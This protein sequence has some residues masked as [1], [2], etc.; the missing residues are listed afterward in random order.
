MSRYASVSLNGT[1]DRERWIACS[2]CD[3]QT[4]HK[5]LVSANTYR[6]FGPNLEYWYQYEIVQCQ[7]CWTIS[8]LKNWQSSDDIYLDDDGKPKLNGHEELY[9]GRVAGRHKLRNSQYLPSQIF[10]IYNETHSA[11]CNKL[12][13]LAGVGIRALIEVV[14]KN[15]SAKGS[16]LEKKI[17][18]LVTIGVL[19]TDGASILHSLRIMGNQAAH[20]VK[21]HS[22]TDLN[23][24]FDVVEHLLEGVYLLPQK[25]KKLPKRIQNP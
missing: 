13:V 20:E 25:A 22:E 8:F 6:D 18:N 19:T 3:S 16:D 1:Q 12:Y 9:P 21:P 5:V 15:K 23:I 11:L 4:C 2:E 14:C 7:G 17:D 10:I 24:A